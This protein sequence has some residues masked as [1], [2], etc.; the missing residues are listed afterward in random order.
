[1]CGASRESPHPIR[2][3]HPTQRPS[4]HGH[5]AAGRVSVCM[6]GAGQLHR[7]VRAGVCCREK[8]RALDVTEKYRA[9]DV[10]LMWRAC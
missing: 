6:R 9:L 10:L 4:S 5:R 7:H 1:M 3:P 2:S 8:D